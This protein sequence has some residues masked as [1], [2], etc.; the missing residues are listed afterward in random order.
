VVHKL[1]ET[2]REVAEANGR[3]AMWVANYVPLLAEHQKLK[4]VSGVPCCF[5]VWMVIDNRSLGAVAAL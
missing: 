5:L 2:M 3:T 1:D 4:E